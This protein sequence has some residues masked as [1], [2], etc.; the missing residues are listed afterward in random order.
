MI[1]LLLTF[2][3]INAVAQ[4]TRADS[5]FASLD[6]LAGYWTS[7]EEDEIIEEIWLAPI[8]SVMPGLHRETSGQ[9][10]SF[11]EYLRI[12]RTGSELIYFANPGGGR[13]TPFYL[14]EYSDSFVVF[15][16]DKHDFPQRI[17]YRLAEKDQLLV[18]VEGSGR[19]LEWRWYK[20]P[21]R[22]VRRQ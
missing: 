1:L 9:T 19:T 11:F 3:C 22:P 18:V 15:K 6:W 16:N 10:K 14:S 17:S 13:T 7:I 4:Q 5:A 12:E 8:D 2:F 21:F 20:T